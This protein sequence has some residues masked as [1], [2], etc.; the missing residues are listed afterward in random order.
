VSPQNVLLSWEGEVK[1]TDFGIAKA[2]DLFGGRSVVRDG[3]LAGK[4]AYTSPEQARGEEVDARS[5]IFSLGT[6]LY[7]MLSGENPFRTSTPGDTLE[8]VKRGEVSTSP[9][10]RCQAGRSAWTRC[11]TRVRLRTKPTSSTRRRPTTELDRAR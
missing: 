8:K 6:L 5:D 9:G 11:P 2:R 7:E 1:I 4:A 3:R 10:S